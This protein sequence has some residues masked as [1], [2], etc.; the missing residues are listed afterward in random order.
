MDKL[1]KLTPFTPSWNTKSYWSNVGVVVAPSFAVPLS[2]SVCSADV[3]S[4]EIDEHIGSHV[5]SSFV[6][7]MQVLTVFMIV[8][9][10]CM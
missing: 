5:G 2:D 8:D 10:G 9:L 4:P 6:R 3:S 1:H 7:G